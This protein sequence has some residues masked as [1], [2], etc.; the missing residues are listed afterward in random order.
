MGLGEQ[1]VR[2]IE[3]W[4]YSQAHRAEVSAMKSSWRPVTNGVPQGQYWVP[5]CLTSSLVIWMM[6][7]T[8]PSASLQMIADNK[9]QVSLWP[10]RHTVFWG[11]LAKSMASRSREIAFYSPWWVYTWSTLSSSGL[12]SSRGT[13]SIRMTGLLKHLSY[14]DR[15]RDLGPFSLEN[16]ERRP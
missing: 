14:E 13:E 9:C 1:T 8:V 7:K 10:R 4:L 15:L 2:W 11:T 12:P 3:K 16:T 5:S 6:G